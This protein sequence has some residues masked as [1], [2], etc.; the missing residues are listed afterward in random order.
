MPRLGSR[1]VHLFV[2]QKTDEA[3]QPRHLHGHGLDVH[4]EEAVP[5]QI[6]LARIGH[7]VAVKGAG[8]LFLRALTGLGH[9]DAGRPLHLAGPPDLVSRVQLAQHVHQLVEH[10]HGEGAAAAGRVQ[11]ADLLHGPDQPLS[12]RAVNRGARRSRPVGRALARRPPPTLR[13]V[14]SRR[15]RSVR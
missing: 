11:D 15:K 4:A 9:V 3:A 13:P 8:D 12:F 1:V 5:D 7:L 6:Q 2:H 14:S 10:A